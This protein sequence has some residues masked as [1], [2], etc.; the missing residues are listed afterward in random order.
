METLI[1]PMKAVQQRRDAEGNLLFKRD[2]LAD[3][4]VVDEP[5]TYEAVT[6]STP[7]LYDPAEY[8]EEGNPRYIVNV[9]AVTEENLPK[10]VET[11][12]GQEFVRIDQTNGLFMNGN[13]WINEDGE[14]PM[15]PGKRELVKINV[16]YI[17]NRAGEEVLGITDIT[18]LPTKKGK[19]INMNALFAGDD[20]PK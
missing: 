15:L 3:Y 9:K 5:G 14:E 8:G 7:N 11:L 2:W 12:D 4:I 1:K 13:I 18:V 16:N 6:T 10:V 20:M 19:K 17:T